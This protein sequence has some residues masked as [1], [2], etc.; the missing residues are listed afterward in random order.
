MKHAEQTIQ[1]LESK[2]QEINAEARRIKT[3]INCLCEV[4]G[5]P[6]KYEETTKES[7][8][9]STIRPDKYYGQP[10][11]TAI[12]EVLT[13]RGALDMG[14]ATLDEIYDELAA[15]GFKFTGKNEGIKKRGLAISM[16]KNP[17][18]HRLPNDTWGLREWYP[19]AKESKES[20]EQ[21]TKDE[22]PKPKEET[23]K[24]N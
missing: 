7:H 12:T 5:K 23:N 17:K 10:Q 24:E 13:K 22:T 19:K 2:L 21:S 14:A 8:K 3:A 15:G 4:M 20:Q 9:I 16:S 11:A 6:P 18:F 1:D